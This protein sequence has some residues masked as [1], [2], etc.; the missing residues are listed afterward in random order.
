MRGTWKKLASRRGAFCNAS[1][2]GSEVPTWSGRT[3]QSNGTAW[4]IGSTADVS[5]SLSAA[6]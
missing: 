5:R 4:V 3:G 2:T 6:T 1:S